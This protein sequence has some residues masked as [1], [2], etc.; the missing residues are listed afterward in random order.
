MWILIL[1]FVLR[2]F[3]FMREINADNYFLKRKNSVTRES[4][5]I[6]SRILNI[7]IKVISLYTRICTSSLLYF[8]KQC[9]STYTQLMCHYMITSLPPLS[10]PPKCIILN[11]H[12]YG[13]FTILLSIDFPR[14]LYRISISTIHCGIRRTRFHETRHIPETFPPSVDERVHYNLSLHCLG[15]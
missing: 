11:N 4:Q 8:I 7:M 13:I 9:N 15:V 6:S 1:G 5:K 14:P 12:H 10:V 2:G 3:D